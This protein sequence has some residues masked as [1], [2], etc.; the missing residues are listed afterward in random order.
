MRSLAQFFVGVRSEMDKVRWPN[1]KEMLKYSAATLSFIVVFALFFIA[2]D[3]LLGM[4]V[5]VFG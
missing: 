5:K 3:N 2:T 4:I 1:R